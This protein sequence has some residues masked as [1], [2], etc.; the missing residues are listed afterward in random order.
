MP[1]LWLDLLVTVYL[2]GKSPDKS[3]KDKTRWH[4]REK[5]FSLGTW[6]QKLSTKNRWFHRRIRHYG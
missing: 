3:Y 4:Q 2:E 5:T 6:V 1:K